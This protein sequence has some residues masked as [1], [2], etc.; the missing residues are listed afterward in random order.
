M[1]KGFLHGRDAAVSYLEKLIVLVEKSSK[2]S[3]DS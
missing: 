1:I 2:H 3:P